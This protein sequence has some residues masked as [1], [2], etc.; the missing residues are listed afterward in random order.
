MHLYR[1]DYLVED[2]YE[3]W[4]MIERE[5][6]SNAHMD[7]L[8]RLAEH[9]IEAGRHQEGIGACYRVLEKD[10]CHEDSYRLL[11]RAT[12]ASGCGGG[13]CASTASARG[14]SDGSMVCPP[15]PKPTPSTRACCV[16]KT[17]EGYPAARKVGRAGFLT[18][19]RHR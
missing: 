15:R 4:T 6:L 7:M 17:A 5:R 11:M 16:T 18:E 19:A 8:G 14:R 10:R 2:L 12:P 13:L 3:D 1:G 9:Y